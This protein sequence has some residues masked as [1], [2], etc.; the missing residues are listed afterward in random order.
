MRNQVV[1]AT[2]DSSEFFFPGSRLS[3][4][5]IH[6]FSS[7]PYEMRFVGERIKEAGFRVLAPRLAGH[8][9][10]STVLRAPANDDW[11][12]SAVRALEQIEAWGDPVLL[13]GESLGA[14]IAVRLAAEKPEAVAGVALLASAF[15]LSPLLNLSVGLFGL[16][17]PFFH[18]LSLPTARPDVRDSQARA[19][20]PRSTWVSVGA[21]LEVGR[22]CRLARNVLGRLSQPILA[23]HGRLDHTT[24]FE[25]NVNFLG[26]SL[27]VSQLRVVALEKSF[28]VVA[29]DL[30]KDR[31][32]AELLRFA[33]EL[34]ASRVRAAG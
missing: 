15:F 16:L 29:V 24:P 19:I 34:C 2:V 18:A 5:L 21:V 1:Q 17:P 3:V 11:Y 20:Q 8:D 28:H 6:G 4:L 25:K 10:P 12:A 26:R 22:A 9:G 27:A 32:S 7:T 23:I 31:V 33:T 13:V 14:A 30:E